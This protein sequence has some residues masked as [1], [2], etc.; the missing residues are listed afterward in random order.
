MRYDKATLSYLDVKTQGALATAGAWA[1]KVARTHINKVLGQ[2]FGSGMAELLLAARLPAAPK[3][4]RQV[5]VCCGGL[6]RREE[7]RTL[8]SC[9]SPNHYCS[10]I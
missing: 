8:S 5:L 9:S 3:P 4:L 6:L 2:G 10:G 1:G 7:A